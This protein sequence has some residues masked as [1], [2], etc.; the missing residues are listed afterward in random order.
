MRPS[1][2]VLLF[3]ALC[4]AAA[5][6]Q[7]SLAG[8]VRTQDGLPLPQLVITLEGASSTQRSVTG[9]DGRYRIASLPPG[10]YTIGV[11]AP[12]LALD[13]DPRVSVAGETRRDVLLRPAPVHERILVAATRGDAA[14]S[15]LGI[16][17]SVIDSERIAE[18]E[19]PA[20]LDLMRELPGVSV[21]RAGVIG[22]QASVFVR[23]GESSFARVLI[24]GVPVN[25][26]GGF[27]N[28]AAQFPLELGRVELVRGAASSLYGTDALAGV[29]HLVTRSA[30]LGER[31]SFSGE[32]E[33]G[34]FG[35]RR[36]RGTTSG[37]GGRFDWNAGLS[38]LKTDNEQPN[39]VFEQTAGAATFGARLNERST[40]RAVLRGETSS[41]GTPGQ[42]A[43]G[44]PDLDASSDHD[45]LV[46]SLSFRH[47]RGT[48]LHELHAGFSRTGQL[49]QDPL[50]SGSYVPR[51]AGRSAAFPSF[52]YPNALG[53]QNDTARL[54]LGYQVEAQLGGSNLLTAGA[55]LEHESGDIG[56]RGGPLLSPVRTNAGVYVQ[57]RALFGRLSLTVGG[58]IERNDSY[59]TRAVPRVAT[60]WRLGP[61]TRSTTLRASAG[62]GIKEPSFF[63][64]FGVDE[65]ALGNP[66]LKPERSRSYDAGVEQR[67]SRDRLRFEATLFQH[68]YL[69][70][71]AY[72]ALSF[73][74][75][76]ASFE[77]LGRT[78]GRGME[79]VVEA[80]PRDRLRLYAQYTLLDGEVLLSTSSSP[81]YAVGQPLLRRP[82]H[83]GSLTASLAGRRV[84]GGVTLLLVGRRSDSDFLGL[85]LTE[86]S[87][88][89]RLDARLRAALGRGV[90]A[91][92]AAENL[93]NREYQEIL[94][95]PALGR[96]L[97][98]GVRF[99]MGAGPHP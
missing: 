49:S 27:Y 44:R 65:F 67:L 48:S 54:A 86:S 69:D 68:D 95:Y 26:P 83:Q 70:Q 7:A 99:H 14:A 74:P 88:Y 21:A 22:Q 10:D 29:V 42:T 71:I 62:A 28:F 90:V 11:E 79:L 98:A 55:E 1:V 52:D 53:Y 13:G 37:S 96:A 92:V 4:P 39:S 9:P 45:E 77:N 75:F 59:G 66:D 43:F 6:G 32:A 15:G 56:D 36:L 72:Q 58:R 3:P 50:D 2:F 57:D 19:A 34:G 84:S 17:V 85:E 31:P 38:Y 5:W 61:V 24:D 18:R 12:G 41:A 35:W 51:Y 30:A 16:G 81:L 63:Q 23:G 97:R 87:G 89:A 80:A 91:F 25:E 82:R 73:T 78:R 20:F 64:S 46:A 94:G 60:A 40:L 33:G 47:A 93:L 8:N 76:R